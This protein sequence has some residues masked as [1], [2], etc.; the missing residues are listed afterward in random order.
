MTLLQSFASFLKYPPFLALS[1]V[2]LSLIIDALIGD[3]ERIH[4]VR[5]IGFL[6]SRMEGF[7][8]RL[9]NR[10]VGGSLL[11]LA[12]MTISLGLTA[13]ALFISWTDILVYLI[14]SAILL[15][16]M[17][18]F[19]SMGDHIRRVLRGLD[20]GNLEEA[21]QS[22]SL[23]VRRDTTNMPESLIC[24]AAIES[25]SEG[26]VDG[27]ANSM[28]FFSLFG[29]LGSVF[30]RVAS[31]FDSMVAYRN[32]RYNLFGR[33]AAYLDTAVNY[34]PARISIA[35]F[36]PATLLMGFRIPG[37]KEMRQQS[38]NLESINAG[39]PISYFAL[40]MGIRLEKS[41]HYVVNENGREP[42]AQ[43]IRK[44]MALFRISGL[45]FIVEFVL[46]LILFLYILGIN[47]F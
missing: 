47:F 15:K 8:Y 24:S 12:V 29:V 46:P 5:G 22:I 33:G 28:F 45:I 16:F 9:K 31:T 14:L 2:A 42:G 37:L 40:S 19:R 32:S 44:A 34:V 10:I 36:A 18:A 13:L 23:M 25:I 21:R 26:F 38:G 17:F 3:P 39:W 1:V 35:A 11:I 27:F 30:A 41:G 20:K 7:F 43:D 4:P 6:I